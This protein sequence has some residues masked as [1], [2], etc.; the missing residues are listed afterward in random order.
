MVEATVHAVAPI[1]IGLMGCT[2][3]AD[4]KAA[5]I[6]THCLRKVAFFS[7]SLPPCGP[8]PGLTDGRSVP[9]PARPVPV[10]R[11]DVLQRRRAQ[12]TCGREH[13]PEILLPPVGERKRSRLVAAPAVVGAAEDPDRSARSPPTPSG[14]ST[15]FMQLTN[16]S[17]TR[18][19]VRSQRGPA[20]PTRS[21]PRRSRP[22]RRRG[23]SR[24]LRDVSGQGRAAVAQ[25]HEAAAAGVYHGF[26]LQMFVGE[27]VRRETPFPLLKDSAL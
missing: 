22:A 10:L 14:P 19:R 3:P 6:R 1:Q 13:L 20:G 4:R 15:R 9:C 2:L 5:S 21:A 26:E 23:D 18:E 25:Q 16:A 8:A 17:G 24:A 7:R 12:V 11:A 27:Y